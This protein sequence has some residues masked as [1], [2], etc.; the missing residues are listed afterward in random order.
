MLLSLLALYAL[1]FLAFHV[2]PVYTF[3]VEF[4]VG[5]FTNVTTKVE[6]GNWDM[7]IVDMFNPPKSG[8]ALFELEN[9]SGL[10]TPRNN[11]NLKPGKAVK[12]TATHGGSTYPL[13]FGRITQV[14][15][16]P[17]LGA[18]T[19]LIEAV[20]DW[21]RVKRLTYSTSLFAGTKVQ[22]IFCA[23]M[24]L[25]SVQSFS[26]DA[27]TDSLDFVWYRDTPAQDAL[28]GLVRSGNYSIVVD[29]NGTYYLR[30]RYWSLFAT[31]INTYSFG[32]DARINLSQDSVI[33]RMKMTAT[34][35]QLTSN[36]TT[37]AFTPSAISIPASS[38]VGFWVTFQDPN[39]PSADTPVHSL[40]TP[41]ASTDYFA[42]VNCDG[43]GTNLTAS[44]SLS[45]TP[46][47]ASAVC[48]IF[49]GGG[50]NAY[51]SRFQVRGYP[52]ARLPA[53][54]TRFDIASS[55]AIFGIRDV[56]VDNQLI[57]N[58]FFMTGL[59]MTIATERKDGRDQMD[60]TLSNEFPDVLANNPGGLL[61]FIDTFSGYTAV[62][63]IRGTS[64]DLGLG[65]GLRHSVKYDAE[66]YDTFPFLVLD[67]TT[68]GKLDSGRLLAI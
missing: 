21:D 15:V 49:N 64:H 4:T 7:A 58:L 53:L 2:E 42:A 35:R 46:F 13:F 37:L 31:A 12:L 40:V 17:R 23:L 43:T 57:Q 11:T 9:D 38:G 22:S 67:H 52:V 10:F 32:D 19:S 27:I 14:S 16:S 30:D 62:W 54:S 39:E 65:E 26:A 47:A 36:I 55:Q 6:R 20:D 68:M 8:R 29:G 44:L 56:T 48:S 34:P 59:S 45:F 3:S 50:T 41:I 5:S 25:S 24:S 28:L 63:R 61:P 51:L 66:S 60:F 18:R 1:R 33:N